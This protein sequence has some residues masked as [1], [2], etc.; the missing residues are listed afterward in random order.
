LTGIVV[1]VL[2]SAALLIAAPWIA[3]RLGRAGCSMLGRF[4]G[5]LI[6]IMAVELILDGI[7]SV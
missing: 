3:T 1:A 7:H 4:N 6:V 5:A 2:A